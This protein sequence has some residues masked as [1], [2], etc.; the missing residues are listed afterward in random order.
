MN[1]RQCLVIQADL[2]RRQ[3]ILDLTRQD[4]CHDRLSQRPGHGQLNQR[5]AHVTGNGI[6]GVG[7]FYISCKGLTV[8]LGKAGTFV[9]RDRKLPGLGVLA[10]QEALRSVLWTR[11][12]TPCRVHS[13]KSTSS[14]SLR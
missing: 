5:Q 3:V 2:H 8:E 10:C 9:V 7:R 1:A 11:T 12:P 4:A 13:G 14:E 6:Q